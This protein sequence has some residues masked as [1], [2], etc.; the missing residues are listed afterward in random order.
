MT[1]FYYSPER[2]VSIGT[3][4]KIGLAS[5]HNYSIKTYVP[6]IQRRVWGYLEYRRPLDEDELER[7]ELIPSP[8]NSETGQFF[9]KKKGG[10][11]P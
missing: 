10:E 1:Y 8:N 11:T 6:E 2:P 7:Y 3:H 9:S 5:F 4:P